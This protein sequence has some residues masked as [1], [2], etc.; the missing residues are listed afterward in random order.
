LEG[1][2]MEDD[3]YI[4]MDMWSILWSFVIFYITYFD[5]WYCSW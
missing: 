3:G 1:L 4:F 5:I 2:A